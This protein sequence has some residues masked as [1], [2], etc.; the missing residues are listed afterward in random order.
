M[1]FGNELSGFVQGFQTGFELMEGKRKTDAAI[2][3]S[4]AS[5]RAS[6]AATKLNEAKLE[7]ETDPELQQ[8]KRDRLRLELD[9]ARVGIDATRVGMD[10]TKAGITHTG[11]LTTKALAEAGEYEENAAA[12]RAQG[13]AAARLNTATAVGQELEN[14]EKMRRDEMIRQGLREKFGIDAPPPNYDTG[15]GAIP[16]TPGPTSSV[17]PMSP[18]E[19][20]LAIRTIVGEAAG[21]PLEGQQAV[22]NVILNRGTAGRYG[23]STV[24]DV[25]LAPNQFEPWSTRRD[26]LMAIDPASPAY[27]QAEQALELAMAGDVTNGATHF[28]NPETVRQRRGGSL[29]AWAQGESQTI[30]AHAF[31]APEGRV[32]AAPAPTEGQE[33]INQMA[34]VT[35]GG[36]VAGRAPYAVVAQ[37]ATKEGLKYTANAIG[38]AAGA[39]G[40]PIAPKDDAARAMLLGTGAAS[41]KDMKDAQGIVKQMFGEDISEAELNLMTLAVTYDTYMEM[42]DPEA[43]KKVAASI[44]QYY[45]KAS[46]GYA[47]IARAAA[48]KGDVDAATKAVIKAYANI[49]DGNEIE[50][51]KDE[52]TGRLIIRKTDL[53]TGQITSENAVTPDE[54]M[55]F[56]MEVDPTKFEGYILQAA[57]EKV[58]RQGVSEAFL[59]AHPDHP[60]Y[61]GMTL[62]EIKQA[63]AMAE[64]SRA[65]GADTDTYSEF[66]GDDYVRNP[67]TGQIETDPRVIS[68]EIPENKGFRYELQSALSRV[69]RDAQG[70]P[71]PTNAE[72]HSI[73]QDEE[74]LR[75]IEEAADAIYKQGYDESPSTLIEFLTNTTTGLTDN[76]IP[77][78]AF[79]RESIK[80]KGRLIPLPRSAALLIIDRNAKARRELEAAEAEAQKREASGR[81]RREALPVTQPE[82]GSWYNP[83]GV[84][85]GV[86]TEYPAGRQALPLR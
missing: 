34:G 11:A 22:A 68:Q 10:A 27:K 19:R 12:D 9:E 47:A 67:A 5:I 69:G 15:T 84:G 42:G 26:E 2:R 23:G 79:D 43:A 25:V 70:R 81:Q 65:G 74:H 41:T 8:L 49:P 46:G 6:E 72:L 82:V 71:D 76:P 80:Y 50:I 21:Q 52:K 31:Y 16:A 86:P 45:R 28:L 1:A 59:A 39:Q 53:E 18:R 38:A 66:M 85:M 56:V 4:E 24:D 20:D 58:E 78:D 57:G 61:A 75:D 13:N 55:G 14:R 30:G 73:L 77:Q 44:L 7:E 54:F 29:P 48:T 62:D 83:A 32:S 60:E 35:S 64:T 63:Q 36:S 3:E 17:G 33:A 51:D 37:E 40:I